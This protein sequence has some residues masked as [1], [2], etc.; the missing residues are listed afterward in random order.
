MGNRNFTGNEQRTMRTENNPEH[1][2][3]AEHECYVCHE[4][5]SQYLF[6]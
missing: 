6:M 3:Q 5:T 2:A 4:E 1:Q